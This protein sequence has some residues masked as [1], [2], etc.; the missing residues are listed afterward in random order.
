MCVRKMAL[1]LALVAATGCAGQRGLSPGASAALIAIG[2]AVAAVGVAESAGCSDFSK[3]EGCGTD[4][5]D[6]D[7]AAG[8]PLAVAGATMIA[9][10]SSQQARAARRL[11]SK[12]S[13]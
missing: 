8:I 2:T 1:A 9:I 6:P 11:R 13:Q 3:D 4:R 5:S 10:G 7:P 12:A